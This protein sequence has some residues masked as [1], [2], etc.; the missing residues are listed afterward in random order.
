MAIVIIDEDGRR[1]YLFE[2]KGKVYRIANDENS[3]PIILSVTPVS[4]Q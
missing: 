4:E 2:D 3:N 1:I